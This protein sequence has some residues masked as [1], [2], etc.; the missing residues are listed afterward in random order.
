MR[1]NHW[2][3]PSANEDGDA[4]VA[5]DAPSFTTDHARSRLI[6]PLI[7][8]AGLLGAILALWLSGQFRR[9]W[10]QVSEAHLM[11]LALVLLIGMLLP[12]I[13]ATRWRMTMRAL[14]TEIPPGTAAEITVSASLV[15]Y[16][17]PGYLGA[18][19]KAYLANR[20]L[21]APYTR[22]AV[23]M[24]FEQGL[25]FLVLVAGSL[26]ALLL[27]GPG[28]L[29]DIRTG[30]G[31]PAWLLASLAVCAL[32]ACVIAVV[33]RHTVQRVL[34]RIADAFQLLGAQVARGP[35][36]LLTLLYWLAQAL[37]VGLLL[38]ALDLPM[39]FS[40]WLALATLPLLAGQV[41]PLPG[42]IGA[43]EATIVALAGA[44]GASTSGLLGLA[45]LQRVLLVLALPLSLVVLRAGRAAGAWR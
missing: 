33:F 45:V 12:V 17:S 20:S 24:A 2:C 26:L 32:A 13:H 21:N 28:V 41:V 40:G 16:A 3:S 35:V 10:D 11:P 44:T 4:Q 15:N 43:R 1:C 39:S 25:D 36:A 42:G 37:V 6:V 19:A 7:F 34:A 27:I 9:A 22:S 23:S 8:W 38:L 5:S 18:P 14:E 30:S 29:A 31:P